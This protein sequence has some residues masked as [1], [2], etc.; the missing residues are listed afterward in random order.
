M[1]LSVQ[2]STVQ[3][4]VSNTALQDEKWIEFCFFV[5]LHRGLSFVSKSSGCVADTLRV[6]VVAKHR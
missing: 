5:R 1:S 2:Q 6:S 4:E 3:M